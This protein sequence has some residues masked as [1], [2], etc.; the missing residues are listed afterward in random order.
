MEKKLKWVNSTQVSHGG[1]IGMDTKLGVTI[2]TAASKETNVP[3]V[4]SIQWR[5]D[6][7]IVFLSHTLSSV[8]S[9]AVLVHT[10]Q[11]GWV[12][13]LALMWRG[14]FKSF[15]DFHDWA[16]ILEKPHLLF[17]FMYLN[18]SRWNFFMIFAH[19][20]LCPVSLESSDE[21]LKFKNSP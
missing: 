3:G 11:K 9:N 6:E 12:C 7:Q 14:K 2:F 5:A 16:G 19:L 15:I 1:W 8:I 13:F 18:I 20:Q 21:F 4:W 10:A 17:N